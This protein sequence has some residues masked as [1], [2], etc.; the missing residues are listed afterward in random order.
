MGISSGTGMAATIAPAD[1]IHRQDAS[2]THLLADGDRRLLTAPLTATSPDATGR[3][4]PPG[5]AV[6]AATVETPRPRRPHESRDGTRS[7][8]GRPG[9]GDGQALRLPL[10][11]APKDLSLDQRLPVRRVDLPK[12]IR[13]IHNRWW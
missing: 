5:H 12:A 8:Q 3:S 11:V 9:R 2:P 13:R 7:P 6:Q 10:G 4:R 1:D